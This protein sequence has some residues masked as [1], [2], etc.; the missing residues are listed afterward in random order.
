MKTPDEWYQKWATTPLSEFDVLDLIKAVQ[1]DALEAAAQEVE[2][3]WVKH[4]ENLARS[5]RELGDK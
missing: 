1:K 5:I 4:R 3:T 2:Q